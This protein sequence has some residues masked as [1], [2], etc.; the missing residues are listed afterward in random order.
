MEPLLDPV[1]AMQPQAP[2]LHENLH[3]YKH[4]EAARPVTGTNICSH[5]RLVRGDVEEGFREADWVYESTYR[6]QMVNV[7]LDRTRPLPSIC[8]AQT[9]DRWVSTVSPL[10][11]KG[12]G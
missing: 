7:C 1:A 3:L 6:T 9:A 12:T 8:P 10:C 4:S 11:R 2:L 5:Y